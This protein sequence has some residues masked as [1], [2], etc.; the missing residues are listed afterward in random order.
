MSEAL[1][2]ELTKL[3]AEGLNWLAFV[4]SELGPTPAGCQANADNGLLLLLSLG[5]VFGRQTAFRGGTENPF[6][7]RARS[8]TQ[9]FVAR[10]LTPHDPAVE[11]LYPGPAQLDLRAWL[12]AGAVQFPSRLGIGIRPDCGTWLAVRSAVWVTPPVELRRL[13][14]RRYPPLKGESP[15]D[16]CTEKP[17]LDACPVDAQRLETG[18]LER[19]IEQRL[20]EATPCAERCGSRS[21]CPVGTEYRYGE[22][23]MRY[24]YGVSLRVIREWKASSRG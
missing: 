16:S 14:I 20:V 10:H 13:L 9:D 18:R 8:L 1:D 15:C 24:H 22:A 4:P 5:P 19:C 11:L 2:Q 7:Q 23:Q 21:A 17:C 3:A 12:Q 6:D